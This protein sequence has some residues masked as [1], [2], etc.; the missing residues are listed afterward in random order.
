MQGWRTNECT[1]D[2]PIYIYIYVYKFL[3]L[4]SRCAPQTSQKIEIAIQRN[5]PGFLPCMGFFPFIGR[6]FQGKTP[7][8]HPRVPS[9]S[10]RHQ[11]LSQLNRNSDNQLETGLPPGT[12]HVPLLLALARAQVLLG[13]K[14]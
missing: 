11:A 8:Y 12:I 10:R 3:G 5:S 4:A 13:R 1:V 7:P 6:P 14:Q 9:P 2:T